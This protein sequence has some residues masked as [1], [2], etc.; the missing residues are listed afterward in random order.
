MTAPDGLLISRGLRVQ[1]TAA[2]LLAGALL[3]VSPVAAYSSMF[4][5]LVAFIPALFFALFVAP[6]IGPDS[7][8][9]LRAAVIGEAVKILITALLC[10]AVFVWVKP[11]LPAGFSWLWQWAF[12]VEDWECFSG[13]R[14]S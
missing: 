14:R 6:K 8:A 9:F 7:A 3:L 10:I 5:S 12:S 2:L 11:W 13:Y 4:G 1:S